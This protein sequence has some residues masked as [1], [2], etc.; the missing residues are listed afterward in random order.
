VRVLVTGA[1]GFVG[2]AL[3]PRLQR[4][5]FLVRGTTRQT[6]HALP[7]SVETTIAELH[8]DTDWRPVLG[9]VDA[10]VHLAARVHVMHDR[11][12]DPLAEFRRINVQGTE[13]LA[14]QAAAAGIRRFVF[15]SSVKV[16]GEAG[17]YHEQD[18]P[19]PVDPYGI[20]KHEAESRL[21][22]VA[23]NTGLEVVVVRPPL[24]YGPGARANFAAL[25]RAVAAGVPLPL[26]AIHNRRS[27]IAV[28]NLADFI[29]TC[30]R[31]PAAANETFLVS[32]GEDLSTPALIRRLARAMGRRAY[33][34]PVPPSILRATAALTGTT[35]A[36]QRLLDTLVVDIA[37]ARRQLAWTPPLTVDEGLALAV[38]AYR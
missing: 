36:A 30:L 25:T 18:R 23:R 9:G 4:E 2:R 26:G 6:G 13:N 32:D 8:P 33:L 15:V 14:R 34:L 35:A 12:L 1:S 5:A 19:A 27:L 10:V 7:D 29:V 17:V 24:V 3:L 20:S 11:A 22:N 31:H 16:N 28:D 38:A 21:R 37:K